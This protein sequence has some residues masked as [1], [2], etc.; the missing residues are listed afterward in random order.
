MTTETKTFGCVRMK[1]QIQAAMMAEF[2]R[3]KGEYASFEAFA[4]AKGRRSAWVQRMNRRFTLR[5]RTAA[6]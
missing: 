2:E 5:K 4:R 6:R 3:H 1:D